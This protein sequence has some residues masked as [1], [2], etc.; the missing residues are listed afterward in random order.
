MNERENAVTHFIDFSKQSF[1]WCA[2]ESEKEVTR[3][4]E[5]LQFVID[6]AKRRIK[7]S[8]KAKQALQEFTVT[9][10]AKNRK[11]NLSTIVRNLKEIIIEERDLINSLSPIIHAL[12]FQDRYRQNLENLV[13]MLEIWRENRNNEDLNLEDFGNA[14]AKVTTMPEER[15]ILRKYFKGIAEEQPAEFDGLFF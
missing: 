1:E 7:M 14:L 15:D 6:D 3:I 2:K 5:I 8:D 4:S 9:Y 13:K 11:A 10:S 12:Q